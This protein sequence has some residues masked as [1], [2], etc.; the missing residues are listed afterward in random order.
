LSAKKSAKKEKDM[1]SPLKKLRTTGA[2]VALLAGSLTLVGVLASTSSATTVTGSID[3]STP[4]IEIC[5]AFT[6]PPI[7]VDTSAS[8]SFTITDDGPTYTGP[9]TTVAVTAGFCSDPIVVPTAL[10]TYT[11]TEASAPWY[12]VTA[13]TAAIPPGS[14]LLSTNLVADW[15]DN[16]AGS[17]DVSVSDGSVST[18]DFTNALVTGYT[19]ICKTTSSGLT[20][21]ETFGLTGEDGYSSSV[22]VPVGGCSG[23]IEVP[24]GDLTVVENGTNLHVTSITAYKDGDTSFNELESS[25]VVTG[26]AVVKVWPSSDG[27][28]ETLVTYADDLVGLK[29]CKYFDGELE[30]QPQGSTTL[31][32]FTET[33]TNAAGN[34]PSTAPSSFSLEAGQCS[35]VTNYAP[36]TVVTITESP[37]PGTKVGEIVASGAESEV[38]GYPDLPNATEQ[39]VIGTPVISTAG[40]SGNE[41]DVSFINELAE[42]STLKICKDVASGSGTFTF[43][44]AG[45]QYVGA[46]DAIKPGLIKVSVVGGYC[47]LPVTDL[48]Y[49]STQLVTESGTTGW[50]ASSI[51]ISSLFTNVSLYEGPWNFVPTTEDVLSAI[52][53]GSAGGVST[54][55]V[56]M[57]EGPSM[58]IVAWTNT[59]PPVAALAATPG[60]VTVAN[61]GLNAGTTTAPDTADAVSVAATV[62][63]NV[64]RMTDR[65]LVLKLRVEIKAA[66][67]KLSHKLSKA[68]RAAERK[69]LAHLRAEVRHLLALMRKL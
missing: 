23:P 9:V 64:Q 48:P 26:T 45:P 18:V 37:Q 21:N 17:A 52:H 15:M 14:Y 61:P 42:P 43:T 1:Q 59:D 30:A 3:P 47:G 5:K 56:T 11:I 4:Y 2:V 51:A 44:V 40:V 41:A 10:D 32:T 68:A 46:T 50:Q 67:K 36:G 24:A 6:P 27:H 49:N 13:I 60:P 28:L 7:S 55:D 31:Y 34:G 57:S 35:Y 54:A 69:R 20:G 33:A 8:F 58:T 66:V 65:A 12:Q 63:Q 22:T 62:S 38:T 39:I 19:E 25:D 16:S 53:L 29:V